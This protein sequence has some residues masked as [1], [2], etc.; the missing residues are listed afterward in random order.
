MRV[1]NQIHTYL[2][3]SEVHKNLSPKFHKIYFQLPQTSTHFLY[4]YTSL[5]Y[6]NSNGE[7]LQKSKK[8]CKDRKNSNKVK[9]EIT[10]DLILKKVNR[11][12]LT[13]KICVREIEDVASS[14][15]RNIT[16]LARKATAAMILIS[17]SVFWT[18]NVA[19][20]TTGTSTGLVA[21]YVECG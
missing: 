16:E 14:S 15:N 9:R 19:Q 4:T 2:F 13:I 12:Q 21:P 6:K 17:L 20:A 7:K 10:I 8:E 1:S 3:K 11:V 5:T 18:S